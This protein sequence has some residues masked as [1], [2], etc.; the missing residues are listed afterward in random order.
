MPE[1]K[2]HTYTTVFPCAKKQCIIKFFVQEKSQVS[3]RSMIYNY[4]ELDIA[5]LQS[6]ARRKCVEYGWNYI[7]LYS[8]EILIASIQ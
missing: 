8:I 2:E 6:A 1:V 5:E 4:S 3:T 7:R